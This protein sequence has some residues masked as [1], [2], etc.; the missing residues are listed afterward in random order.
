[1][2]RKDSML[3]AFLVLAPLVTSHA[4][5]IQPS[6]APVDRLIANTEAFLKNTPNDHRAHYTLARIHYLAFVNKADLVA[7]NREGTPPELAP[8]FLLGNFDYHVV[9][10]HARTLVL[11]EYGVASFSDIPQ[12][13]RQGVWETVRKKEEELRQNKWQPPQLDTESLLAHASKAVSS[14]KT[15]IKLKPDSG[16]YYLGLASL[17][18]Q[19]LQFAREAGLK[20]HPPEL[21]TVTLRDVKALYF[22]A[23]RLTIK[24]DLKHKHIPLGGL[25]SLVA[26]EAANAYIELAGQTDPLPQDEA[27]RVARLQRDLDRFHNLRIGAITPIVFSLRE[28]SSLSDLLDPDTHVS[29]DLD[30]DGTTETWPWVRPS[31][32][33]LVWDPDGAG[34]IASG[35][36]L[37]GTA[38]WWI[39]FPNGYAALR[40][41]DD[42]QDGRLTGPEL[43]G[44]GA[45]FDANSN[46]RSEPGE[47]APVARF[48]VHAIR[49]GPSGEVDGILL[50]RHGIALSSG[51]SVPTYDW[52][53]VP[54]DKPVSVPL[55]MDE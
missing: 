3:L 53:A 50:N 19:Y 43:D 15:A 40:A 46:G 10:Q 48:G 25:G 49:T 8:D 24:E 16:L 51:R 14:F 12:E 36:Q 5:F 54:S 44:I 1:M 13:E 27:Q 47:V 21:E 26:Y 28:H 2:I 11:E 23:Y 18:R 33:I 42:D 39:L 37:F 22:R 34:T 31:T 29:F 41:L 45:W 52:I 20:E 4:E 7:I 35:R 32:G 6:Y 30:G 9:S 17:Y 38:T 55:R